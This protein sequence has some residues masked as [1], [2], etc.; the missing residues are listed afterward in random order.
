M[1][2]PIPSSPVKSLL[3]QNQ[4]TPEGSAVKL[5]EQRVGELTKQLASGW[6]G[7]FTVTIGG[8]AKTATVTKGIITNVV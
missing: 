6:S 3:P 1:L 8:V 7:S 2:T 4:L 5:L